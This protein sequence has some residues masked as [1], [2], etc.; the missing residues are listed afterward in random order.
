MTDFSIGA[1]TFVDLVGGVTI[2]LFVVALAYYAV[3]GAGFVS[4]AYCAGVGAG[5]VELAYCAGV[6]AVVVSL[7]YCDEV[8]AEG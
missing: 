4:L 8:G 1:V 6:G 3:V 7:A 5:V 2:T